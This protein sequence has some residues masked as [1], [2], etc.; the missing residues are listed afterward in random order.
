M[1]SKRDVRLTRNKDMV[2]ARCRK[3]GCPWHIYASYDRDSGKFMVKPYVSEHKC[4]EVLKN[5]RLTSSW[6]AK[7]YFG[8]MRE[9]C[10]LKLDGL[11]RLTRN[12]YDCRV[13]L[14]KVRRA[15]DKVVER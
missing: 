5:R 14:T 13:R 10:S 11:A 9:I 8:E 4:N 7:N 6:I 2:R 12:K 1:L 15:R 3:S